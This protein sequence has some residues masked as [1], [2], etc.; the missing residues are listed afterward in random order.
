MRGVSLLLAVGV[1]SSAW[2]WDNTTV[3][4]ILRATPDYQVALAQE[5][6]ALADLETI[7]RLPD[8]EI[9]LEYKWGDRSEAGHKLDLGVTQSFDWPGVYAARREEAKALDNLIS[10]QTVARYQ[11]LKLQIS[12]LLVELTYQNRRLLLLDS[13]VATYDDLHNAYQRGRES[14]HTTL[15]DLKKIELEQLNMGREVID[16]RNA[17]EETL[18]A[19]ENLCPEYD[20]TD[21]ANTIDYPP[22]ENLDEDGWC[23]MCQEMALRT[24]GNLMVKGM[25][26]QVAEARLKVEKRSAL[27]SWSLGYRYANEEGYNFNGVAVGMSVPLWSSRSKVKAAQAQLTANELSLSIVR[28]QVANKVISEFFRAQRLNKDCQ[29]YRATLF[30]SDLPRLLKMALDG[31]EMSL[32]DYL[33]ESAYFL[34]AHQQLLTLERDLALTLAQLNSYIPL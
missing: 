9:E 15:L 23:L 8:P 17:R 19:L 13:I 3:N 33:Q 10:A 22:V 29:E 1:A 14:G 31:G 24:N 27:P 26:Y 7:N 6:A 32:L 18:N 12:Q 21:L 16:A 20:W 30:S 4:D 34:Q 11:E 28:E 5:N 2:A 25:E